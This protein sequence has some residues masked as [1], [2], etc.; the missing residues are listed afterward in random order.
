MSA[1]GITYIAASGD[2]GTS[3]LLT[4]NTPY[5]DMDPEVLMVGG[6]TTNT[7]S[8]GGL[9]SQTG[10]S[11]STGGW[12][13][14]DLF[15]NKLP[16][17][18]HGIGV[19]TNINARLV[20]D[21]ALNADPAT[22][23]WIFQQA[24]E[25]G[26]TTTG[27]GTIGGTSCASP[28]F[29]GCLADAEAE[30]LHYGGLASGNHRFGR[31]APLLYSFDGNASIFTDI[32]SGS[33]G[34]LPNGQTSSCTFGWDFVT[35]WGAMNFD[36]FAKSQALQAIS[37]SVTPTTVTG[38]SPITATVTLS[39]PAP[40]GGIVVNL[41]SNE[42]A[43]IGNGSVLMPA[44]ASTVHFNLNTIGWVGNTT[45]TLGATTLGWQTTTT[46]VNILRANLSGVSVSPNPVL[47]GSSAT[48]TVTLTGP[49]G[50]AGALVTLASSNSALAKVPA[51][52]FVSA[53]NKTATFPI[54]TN[55]VTLN[56]T[57][58]ITGTYGVSA[59]TAVTVSRANLSG[60]TINPSA[61]T[62]GGTVIGT[63]TLNGPAGPSGVQVILGSSNHAVAPVPSGITVPANK[64]SAQFTITTT[65]VTSIT[66]VTLNAFAGDTVSRTL[67]V[68]P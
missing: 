60:Y 28:T 37:Y 10:W 68:R 19:P 5:P 17:W 49:S 31:I 47:G 50:S 3:D 44:G 25:N 20:P 39:G 27:W 59:S 63:V 9:T 4:Q 54:T 66:S 8:S 53:G 51:S 45:V 36:E 24:G 30:I 65:H 56:T 46:L 32:L 35:G 42:G 13:T 21:V 29:A 41:T 34:K 55:A 67:T 64:T 1:Q 26:R 23:D 16:A 33:N 18:Q 58:T 6:T 7:N 15:W 2:S 57:V 48:G 61:V 11:G 22:P 40:A 43:V 12:S 14:L 38:G 62:G 52:V